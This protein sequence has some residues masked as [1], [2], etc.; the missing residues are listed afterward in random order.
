MSEFTVT[1]PDGRDYQVA[2]DT[3]EGAA[4]AVAKMIGQSH[5]PIH[6]TDYGGVVFARP[7][8]STY[9]NS[10][11]Y[12]TSDQSEILQIM[13]GAKPADFMQ[14]DI[15]QER[16]AQSPIMA[17][18]AKVAEGIPFIGSHMDE[19]VGVIHGET[20]R[21]NFRG[22]IGAMEREKP[23]QSMGLNATGTVL[24]AVPMAVG[25]AGTLP[26]QGST[27][28]ARI[29]Q[30]ALVGSLAGATEGAIYGAGDQAGRLQNAQEG[31]MYGGAFGVAGGAMAPMAVDLF[32]RAIPWI[33]GSDV[34]T[35]SNQLGVSSAS[36][37]VIK[38]ALTR[39][40]TDEAYRAL[41]RAGDGAMLADAS[42]PGREL[43]DA[44][45]NAGGQA[46]QIARDAVEDRVTTASKEMTA[47][48]D[49][50]L[51]GP[52]GP[53]AIQRTVREAT[54]DVR[55]AA[56]NKAYAA[57]I[58]YST[59][60]GRAL[61]QFLARVPKSAFDDANALMRMDGVQSRQILAEVG[62]DGAVTFSRLP[63]VRQVHYIIQA[64]EGTAQKFDGQ[65][66][67]GG[68]TP[69]GASTKRLSANLRNTLKGL[70]P[71]FSEAQDIAAD[72]IQQVQAADVGYSM[73]R[74]GTTRETVSEALDGA[75]RAQLRAA[76]QGVRS[77]IDDTLANVKQV[78][79]DPNMDAREGIRLL[80]EMSSR[81]NRDKMQ[82]LLG[83]KR[84][85]DLYSEL[86]RAT[87]AFELRAAISQNSKTAIRQSIQGTVDA[88]TQPGF[89]ELLMG[90]SPAQSARRFA[91]IFTGDLE[92]AKA[93]R[94]MGIYE[95]IATAL[96][97]ARGHKARRALKVVNKAIEGQQVTEQEAAFVGRILATEAV[98]VGYR[99]VDQRLTP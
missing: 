44:A 42:Q 77:Y 58:D 88:Q 11:G 49:R 54:A 34:N 15:D 74:A 14:Q 5:E 50:I 32:K 67:L 6:T 22:L 73:L 18:L 69:L 12:N 78:I 89:L 10:P 39:G 81:A 95:E 2:G 63:D 61:E 85:E 94:Q 19:A 84:A 82:L 33:K 66:A 9:F 91:Q 7:D 71:E 65:G 60:R 48:L 55:Q 24:G 46:G 16:I 37:K 38:D 4:K 20:K 30:G 53:R 57:P 68:Q 93:L 1:G 29:G 25:A 56:Y 79:S 28:G 41:L 17:R 87:V 80:R 97:S 96:T 72:A 70:V 13:E 86:N 83:R 35:I 75:G 31:A 47:A 92:E 59:G 26:A 23:G 99:E 90:G 62:E 98:L 21:D 8:G 52:E 76:E 3:A 64:L 51:G 43:L 36:A 45:A 40:S 27:L